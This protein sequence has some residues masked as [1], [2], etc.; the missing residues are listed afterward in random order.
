MTK[1]EAGKLVYIIKSGYPQMY[2]RFT[3]GDLN[4]Q[5]SIWAAMLEDFTFSEAVA[6]LKMYMATDTKGFPPSPGQ[7][8]DQIRKIKRDPRNE[9]SALE[10]WSLVRK[11]LGNSYYN[12]ESEFEKLP[13]PVKKAIGSPENLREM[14]L[15]PINDVETVE[16]SHF[17]RAY[18]TAVKRA[19]EDAK[20]P[21]RVLAMIEEKWDQA[22][23]AEKK[24]IGSE[25]TEKER[26]IPVLENGGVTPE[27]EERRRIEKEKRI[28]ELEKASAKLEALKTHIAG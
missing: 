27:E 2:Q 19:E 1:N 4:D 25:S 14:S 11:A 3:A 18:D 9:M 22:A 23:I 12:A 15:M 26:L 7:V 24:K 17:I 28:A 6:G 8:I 21:K 5:I 16:Q 13:E 20:I 10:A